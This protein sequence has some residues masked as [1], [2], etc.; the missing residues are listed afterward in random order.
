MGAMG[1][2]GEWGGGE[3]RSRGREVKDKDGDQSEAT[4]LRLKDNER[5]RPCDVPWCTCDPDLVYM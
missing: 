2:M 4:A 3:G 1:E 5:I